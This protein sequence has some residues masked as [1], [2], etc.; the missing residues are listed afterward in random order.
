MANKEYDAIYSDYLKKLFMNKSTITLTPIEK[1][2]II[3]GLE[4]S[5]KEINQLKWV[6]DDLGCTEKLAIDRIKKLIKKI[7]EE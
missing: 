4:L 5:I 3:H 2:N 6:K 1:R 7:Q